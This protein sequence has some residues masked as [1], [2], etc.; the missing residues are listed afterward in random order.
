MAVTSV[1]SF[2]AGRVNSYQPQFKGNKLP[3]EIDKGDYIEK[4]IETEASTGKKWGVGIASAFM[5]GLGQ[6]IN[7]DVGKGFAF[8]AG[9]IATGAAAV[10]G[11][12]KGSKGLYLGGLLSGL[13]VG[14]W[15]IV[16]AVKNAKSETV[17][18][19]P[20]ENA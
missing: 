1:Q 18:I 7:G 3:R 13:G 9:L 12:M 11:M 20:K 8:L 10:A 15:S 17:Q 2:N 14:I 4:H 5:T 19:I 6:F 16:D